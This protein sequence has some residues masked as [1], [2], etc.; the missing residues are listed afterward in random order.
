MLQTLAFKLPEANEESTA[1][2]L[3]L[4]FYKALGWNPKEHQL[5]PQKIIISKNNYQNLHNLLKSVTLKEDMEA[6]SMLMVS[7]APSVKTDVPD[8][9]I[10]LLEGAII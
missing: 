1:G 7:Y 6:V 3:L 8:S 10:L 9:D 2:D 4:S 5:N